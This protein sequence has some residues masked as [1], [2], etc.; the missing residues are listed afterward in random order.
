MVSAVVT[1]GYAEG[2]H[3]RPAVL[4]VK[5]A[6]RFHCRITL[7]KE[8]HRVDCKSML[9][10]LSLGVPSGQEV[11]VE[12]DGEGEREALE[13]LVSLIQRTSRLP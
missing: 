7:E 4:L 10:V 6:C 1:V 2:L 13:A 12:T 3:A 11:R 5:E 9:Q 8:G